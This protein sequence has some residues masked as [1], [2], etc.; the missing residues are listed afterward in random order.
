[1]T[2]DEQYITVAE[3][4]MR[5]GV[6]ERTIRRRIKT[7]E[8]EAT[9]TKTPQGHT[10]H[11]DPASLPPHPAL[12]PGTTERHP[13]G[14][15]WHDG[16]DEIATRQDPASTRQSDAATWQVADTPVG[17]PGMPPG[18]A[19]TPELIELV[20]LVDRLQQSNQQLAGQLGFTQAKLQEAERTIALLMAPKDEPAEEQPAEPE[21]VSWWKRLW[22]K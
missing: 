2:D 5:L 19:D 21:R 15:T 4:A 18:T 3:A 13:A 17:A 1:M 20:R 16:Q 10:W 7:R 14:A 12:P 22:G 9:S 11:V 8:I 6:S